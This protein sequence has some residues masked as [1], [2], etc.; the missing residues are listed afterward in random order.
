MWGEVTRHHV[1][2]RAVPSS[3]S[4]VWQ[5]F[6]KGLGPKNSTIRWHVGRIDASR[7]SMQ[8]MENG[9]L[10][11]RST[12]KYLQ[13]LLPNRKSMYIQRMYIVWVQ[14]IERDGLT[15]HWVS[16]FP[17]HAIAVYFS[18][19]QHFAPRH[20]GRHCGVKKCETFLP[21]NNCNMRDISAPQVR[22][23][24]DISAPMRTR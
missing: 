24:W 12:K 9:K 11:W 5:I 18:S 15:D 3:C 16:G 1:F 4:K 17:Y 20:L 22:H 19:P 23:M 13:V 8:L 21:R 14:V 2:K 6:L 10:G 7:S